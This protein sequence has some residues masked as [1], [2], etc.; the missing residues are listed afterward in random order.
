MT[1]S[2]Q[3]RESARSQRFAFSRMQQSVRRNAHWWLLG[4]ITLLGL[5]AV[6]A[7]AVFAALFEDDWSDK[8]WLEVAKAGIAVLSI[9]V[10]GGALSNLWKNLAERRAVESERNEKIRAELA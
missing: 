1:L 5:L 3:D 7:G 10:L 9:G 6:I 4:S 8:L 2:A